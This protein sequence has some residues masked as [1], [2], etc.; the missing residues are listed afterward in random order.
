[1]EN[2]CISEIKYFIYILLFRKI[3]N[4]KLKDNMKKKNE[5]YGKLYE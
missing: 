4:E 1:M 2:H 3:K 5:E